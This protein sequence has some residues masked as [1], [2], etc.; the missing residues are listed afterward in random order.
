MQKGMYEIK[1]D[2][3]MPAPA[4]HRAG[5]KAGKRSRGKTANQAGK[6]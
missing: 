4:C 3:R 1:K 2:Y 6:P 5:G